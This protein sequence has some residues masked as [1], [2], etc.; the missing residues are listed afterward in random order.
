LKI[1]KPTVT[2]KSS[3]VWNSFSCIYVTDVKQE[4]VICN[5]CH[6]LLIYKPSS[7]TNSLFRHIRSCQ[8]IKTPLSGTQSSINQFYASSNKEPAVPKRIKQ[9][10]KVACAEFAALDCRPFKTIDGIGFKNLAQKI[11]NAGRCLPMSQEMNIEH[12]LP[13]PTTVRKTIL[14]LL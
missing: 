3:T 10:I 12:L 1:V 8:N 9:G 11:F 6:D 4:Y 7:G 14:N 5:Q 2:P 13:H